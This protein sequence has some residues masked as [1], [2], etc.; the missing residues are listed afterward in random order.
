MVIAIIVECHILDKF[1]IRI[2][3][4]DM[5][6]KVVLVDAYL[7]VPGRLGECAGVA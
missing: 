3:V 7:E 5:R 2:V 6:D 1:S 4:D